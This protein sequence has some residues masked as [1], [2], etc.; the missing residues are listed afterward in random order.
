MGDE[1]HDLAESI[2]RKSKAQLLT[3]GKYLVAIIGV[4][5]DASQVRYL[6]LVIDKNSGGC[7]FSSLLKL[8]Q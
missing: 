2:R 3:C 4:T 5:G 8:P 6:E 7:L 1:K